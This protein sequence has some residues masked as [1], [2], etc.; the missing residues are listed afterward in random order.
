VGRRNYKDVAIELVSRCGPQQGERRPLRSGGSTE[1]L[2]VENIRFSD[3]LCDAIVQ[4][5]DWWGVA[6][7]QE[8]G[9]WWSSDKL[10]AGVRVDSEGISGSELE[11]GGARSRDTGGGGNLSSWQ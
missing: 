5:A 7:G 2:F 6:F 3:G 1:E 9:G 8:H 4:C 10:D 11:Q